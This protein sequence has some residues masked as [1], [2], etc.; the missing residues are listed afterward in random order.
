[1][2]GV[3]C[4]EH[5]HGRGVAR[6]D[7]PAGEEAAQ[8]RVQGPQLDSRVENGLVQGFLALIK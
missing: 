6:L 7:L 4:D 2:R 5:P 3:V 1:M 8:L